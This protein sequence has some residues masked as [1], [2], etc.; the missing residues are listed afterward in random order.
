MIPHPIIPYTNKE[1]MS[2]RI[3][4][5]TLTEANNVE[6]V[7]TPIIYKV[8]ITTGLYLQNRQILSNIILC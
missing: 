8:I 1:H 6:N 2:N 7:Q 4:R 5:D 3:T